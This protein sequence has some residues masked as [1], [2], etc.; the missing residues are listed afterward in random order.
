MERFGL[1]EK[2]QRLLFRFRQLQRLARFRERVAHAR[3]ALHP[4]DRRRG[5]RQRTTRHVSPVRRGGQDGHLCEELDRSNFHRKSNKTVRYRPDLNLLN[6]GLEQRHNGVARFHRSHHRGLLDVDAEVAPRFVPLRWGLDRHERTF[7]FPVGFLQR[8]PQVESRESAVFTER[9]RRS[10]QLQDDVHVCE[11]LRG[12]SLR[13]SQPVRV[14]RSDRDEFVS[15]ESWGSSPVSME[16][17]ARCP[18]Y[19][20][21]DRW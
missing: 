4:L 7:E 9:R 11:A 1:H 12:A 19:G 2:Q 5:E 6:L 20:A 8:L 15:I 18:R 17:S 10:H 16:F 3:H 14:H 13:H 21:R